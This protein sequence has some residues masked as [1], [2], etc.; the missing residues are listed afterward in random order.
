MSVKFNDELNHTVIVEDV[1]SD[2]EES[3]SK[4]E[5]YPEHFNLVKE[6]EVQNEIRR[7]NT[8][9]R[10]MPPYYKQQPLASNGL[11][12]TQIS[13]DDILKSMNMRVKDGKLEMVQPMSQETNYAAQVP[14]QHNPQ[15]NSY[16]YNK[17]FKNNTQYEEN[18]QIPSRSLTPEERRAFMIKRQ[19]EIAQQR[20]RISEI[21]STK[22]QFS[23]TNVNVSSVYRHKDLNR[24]FK[25]KF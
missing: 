15:T 11:K 18:P 7:P 5:V 14:Y 20:K 8:Q 1:M 10:P 16:I 25:M 2:E 19:I 13:Y 24:L 21:K 12:K 23:D 17:Y 3:Y 9:Y 4:D 6:D 22:L